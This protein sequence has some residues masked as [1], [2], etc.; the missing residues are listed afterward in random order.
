ELGKYFLGELLKIDGVKVYGPT[1]FEDRTSVVTFNVGGG[2]GANHERI[3]R[4][5]DDHGISVRDG[6]FCAHIYTSQLLNAPRIAHEIRT[7]LGKAGVKK[8]LLMLPGAVRASFAFYNNLD[9]AYKA[10]VAIKEISTRMNY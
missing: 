7:L 4:G 1:E 6:C 10:V 8:D 5:L 9:D 2:F 3:A